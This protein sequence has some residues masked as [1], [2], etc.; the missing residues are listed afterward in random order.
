M[1]SWILFVTFAV[2]SY[3]YSLWFIFGVVVFA[4]WKLNRW[5]YYSSR[6][7]RKV[8]FPMMRAYAAASGLEAGQAEREGREFNLNT[9]LL[10]LL[11]MA[12]PK[13]SVSHEVLIKREFERCYKFYEE[14]LIRQYL[15]EE[16]GI[17][18]SQVTSVLGE[19]RGRMNT[20]NKGLMA[21]MVIASVIEE[22]FSPQDRGEY[23]FQ[24]IS[25]KAD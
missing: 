20:S 24:V 12:N 5:Y 17:D 18:P 21:R 13:V 9:A 10:N 22:Q 25:G 6:P 3:V 7:W 2:L 1:I 11:K 15:V 14:P 23:L 16:N 8:H 4:L 19:I